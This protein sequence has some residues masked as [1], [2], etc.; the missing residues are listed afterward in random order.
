MVS[1]SICCNCSKRV[2]I[3]PTKVTSLLGILLIEGIIL[4]KLSPYCFF[5]NSNILIKLFYFEEI[6]SP[7]PSASVMG[8]MMKLAKNTEIIMSGPTLQRFSTTYQLQLL[9][10]E[11]YSVFMEDFHLELPQSI[12]WGQFKGIFKSQTLGLC[13]TLCGPILSKL[14]HG[15]RIHEGQDGCLEKNLF[16]SFFIKIKW[17]KLSGLINWSTKD[18]E[19]T[20]MIYCIRYGRLQTIVIGWII[21]RQYWK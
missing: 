8:F 19:S 1:F 4:L 21:W 15:N 13:V 6:M 5:I 16:K 3:F 2:A 11:A 7:E 12:K 20:S 10:R 9:L 17:R 18:I 14:R